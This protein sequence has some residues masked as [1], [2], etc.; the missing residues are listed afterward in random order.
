M[1]KYHS[2][3]NFGLILKSQM[4]TIADCLK[5]IKMSKMFKYCSKHHKKM[6]VARKASLIVTR[7][8]FKN[9]MAATSHV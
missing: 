9:K 3:Q 1:P 7:P 4:A 8:S 5:I 2:V 6:Y